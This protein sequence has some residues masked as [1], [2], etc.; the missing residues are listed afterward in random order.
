M[1]SGPSE[2]RVP[3]NIVDRSLLNEDPR[4]CEWRI[5]NRG[6]VLHAWE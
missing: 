3:I 6:T 5:Q 4:R 1:S 2:R